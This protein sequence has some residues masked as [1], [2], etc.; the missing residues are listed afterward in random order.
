MVQRFE[1][2][3][4]IPEEE[5]IRETEFNIQKEVVNIYYHYGKGKIVSKEKSF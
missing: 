3:P 2:D 4:S 5:Q 1:L